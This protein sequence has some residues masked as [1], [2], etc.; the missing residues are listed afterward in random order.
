[1][2]LMKNI[3]ISNS[4]MMSKLPDLNKMIN[5]SSVSGDKTHER[6]CPIRRRAICKISNHLP[7]FIQDGIQ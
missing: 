4:G 2:E 5:K 7:L 1:M 6:A 3:T